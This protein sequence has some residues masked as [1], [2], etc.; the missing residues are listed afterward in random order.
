MNK[1]IIFSVIFFFT[2]STVLLSQQ[3]SVYRIGCDFDQQNAPLIWFNKKYAE[4]GAM[5]PVLWS[6]SQLFKLLENREYRQDYFSEDG[7]LK[8]ENFQFKYAPLNLI[9]QDYNCHENFIK[10]GIE[11]KLWDEEI[12]GVSTIKD[13]VNMHKKYPIC[14]NVNIQMYED[15]FGISFSEI[16][17]KL[18][19]RE[20]LVYTRQGFMGF[21]IVGN[22]EYI[23]LS[24]KKDPTLKRLR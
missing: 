15:E 11:I 9:V 23:Y 4:L 7:I 16:V 17:R 20:L 14:G 3:K 13:F 18:M 24:N 12:K 6:D 22:T 1:L 5:P 10:S 2:F 8:P 19:N 21:M